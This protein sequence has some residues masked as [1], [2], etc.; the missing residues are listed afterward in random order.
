[1]NRNL[2]WILTLGIVIFMCGA[3]T[4]ED[5]LEV[6]VQSRTEG[7]TYMVIDKGV[8]PHDKAGPVRFTHDRHF[9]SFGIDCKVCHH[10]YV[11]DENLWS[12]GDPVEKCE[13]C[14]DPAAPAGG[15]KTLE[16]AFHDNCR[17]CHQEVVEKQA[18]PAPA[19]VLCQG[20]HE[21]P[22]AR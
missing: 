21:V 3:C 19:P 9:E 4:S 16:M 2:R 12:Q 14:H 17:G 15:I 8:Y 18:Y 10:I 1:M 11:D 7:M 22:A 6:P 5:K 13:A 20:C